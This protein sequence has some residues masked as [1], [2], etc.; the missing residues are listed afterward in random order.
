M[1]DET[2]LDVDKAV[3]IQVI[4]IMDRCI[5]YVAI[6]IFFRIFSIFLNFDTYLL[7]FGTSIRI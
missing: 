5:L 2:D 3:S 6:K 4:L 7:V 1:R